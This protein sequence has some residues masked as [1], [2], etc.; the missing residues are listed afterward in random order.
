[1]SADWLRPGPNFLRALAGP[2][3]RRRSTSP[4]RGRSATL[5][6]L[7]G[8]LCGLT[9]ASVG[10][11][12]EDVYF[13]CEDYDAQ[14]RATADSEGILLPN[15]PKGEP[16][17]VA[18][19]F[20]EDGL[21]KLLEGVVDNDVPFTGELPFFW[22]TGPGTL[23]FEPTSDPV[24]DL[25]SLEGCPTCVQYSL[26]FNVVLLG[27]DGDFEG[28]GI[29]TVKMRIPLE[30][31][32]EGE[33]EV[34][35]FADYSRLRIQDLWLSAFGLETEEHESLVGAVA[36]IM[37][38]EIQESFGQTDLLRL[39]SWE[40]SDD[41]KLLA[42]KLI[43]FPE[44][45]TLVLAMQSNL[46]LPAG[47]G[48]AI[49]GEMPMGVPMT[50]DFDTAIFRSMIERLLAE[51]K[52]A[53]I[54]D[55]DGEADPEGNYAVTVDSLVGAPNSNK[56]TAQFKVWRIADGYCGYAVASMDI[57]VDLNEEGEVVLTPG[58]VVVLEG[59]GSGAV[60]AEEKQLVED[61]QKVVDQFKAGVA[62]NLETTINYDGLGME[63]SLIYFETLAVDV[64]PERLS[65]WI[66]FL[67]V[68]DGG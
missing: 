15:V 55:E 28:A 63:G 25:E 66:D 40:I 6:A 37:E 47:G 34:V 1:M 41:I 45:D 30:L 59:E 62:S 33:D 10:C 57:D 16:Y 68:E 50:V 18:L 26:D 56:F 3:A 61:N 31:R 51:G 5:G 2:L 64:E 20:S 38:E 19:K 48:L 65:T 60:A 14:F 13:D 43:V 67:V 8:G 21:N 12:G 35:L 46:P 4:A 52:I 49:D 17:P 39:S 42:R 36:I 24:I 58:E 22:F 53:R 9:L 23:L 32:Q 54:Y 44:Q 11:R 7:L 29:G 27:A